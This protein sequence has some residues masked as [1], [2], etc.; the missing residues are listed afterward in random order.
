M[1]EDIN[2]STGPP[3][4]AD[5]FD[6]LLIQRGHRRSVLSYVFFQASPEVGH[7]QAQAFARIAI[8]GLFVLLFWAA[9]HVDFIKERILGFGWTP[10]PH[11]VFILA[12]DF[13]FAGLILLWL[14][15][16]MHPV[17]RRISTFDDHAAA[18][19]TFLVMLTGCMALG[20]SHDGLRALHMLCVNLFLIYFPF[21]RLMHA[22]T[23][24]ISRAKTGAAMARKG[25][26]A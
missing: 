4:P 14:R 26:A 16:V 21:S 1:D 7:E 22:F 2:N 8:V 11:W 23:F 20:E 13:A 15:R 18:I 17:M 5:G 10:A 24:A 12:A 19:L 3:P 6:G 25:V 9:P